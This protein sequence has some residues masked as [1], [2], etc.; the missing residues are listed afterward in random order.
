VALNVQSMG[1][2]ASVIGFVG[3]DAAAADLRGLLDA[4][5]I[6]TAGITSRPGA[7]TT[8]KTRVVADRQQVVRIDHETLVEPGAEAVEA[9]CDACTRLLPGADGVIIE[10]YGRG[11]VTQAVVDTALNTAA[12]NGIPSGLDPKESHE[13]TFSRL[14]FATPN[15]REALAA[16]GMARPRSDDAPEPEVLQAAGGAL[17]RRWHADRLMITLGP[18]GMCLFDGDRPPRVIPSIAR[19]VFDVSG[20]GDTVIAVTMLGLVAGADFE[21]AAAVANLAAGVVVG[22]LGTAVCTPEEILAEMEV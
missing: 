7:P 17:R 6:D 3:E 13:L 1:G 19:E 14:T 18:G 15:C 12:A 10:D 22:K 4:R 2:R 11:V 9:L 8:V 21:E 5:G 20:A 16:A